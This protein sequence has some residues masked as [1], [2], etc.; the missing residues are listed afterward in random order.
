MSIE[1]RYCFDRNH[2]EDPRVL[3]IL[4]QRT[5][6]IELKKFCV[7]LLE[8]QGSFAYTVSVLEKLDGQLREEVQR[9]GGNDLFIK[10]LDELVCW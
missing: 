4:R 5:T 1:Y 8:S 10:L 7:K 2:P 3:N 9:L 6:D